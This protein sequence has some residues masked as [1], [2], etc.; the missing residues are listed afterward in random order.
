M[1]FPV[2]N[3][4]KWIAAGFALGA[5]STVALHQLFSYLYQGRG[6]CPLRDYCPVRRRRRSPDEQLQPLSEVLRANEQLSSAS[7]PGLP[8]Q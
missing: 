8:L 6:S 4:T 7:E 5:V 3:S 2:A 1:S